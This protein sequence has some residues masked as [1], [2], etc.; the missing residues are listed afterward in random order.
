MIKTAAKKVAWVGRTTSMVF[1]LALVLAMVVGV[2]S[3][4]FGANGQAWILG[5]SNVATAITKLAGA[6]GV[7]GPMLQ[8][9][10]NNGGTDDTALSLGVQSGE[11][12]MRVNS[13]EKVAKLNADKL[14]GLDSARFLSSEIYTVEVTKTTPA[15]VEHAVG[16]SCD[17]GDQAISGGFLQVA[18]TTHVSESAR[19][20]QDTWGVTVLTGSTTSDTWFIQAVC[21]DLPPLRP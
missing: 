7:N 16:I 5:Q 21:A 1:G 3:A 11:P 18:S 12:P 15:N 19:N 8:L 20:S 6:V 10:N 9:I 14:D 4:A 13:S 17:P 2:A